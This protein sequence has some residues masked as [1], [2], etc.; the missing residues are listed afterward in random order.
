MGENWEMRVALVF[1]LDQ[2]AVGRMR[3]V[4]CLPALVEQLAARPSVN[5]RRL[6]AP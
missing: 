1:K 6:P 5:L 2:E 3:S 4:H